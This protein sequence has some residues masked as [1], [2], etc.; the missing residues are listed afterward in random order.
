M[1]FPQLPV[2]QRFTYQGETLVK[3][4][5]LTA[6]NERGGNT[7]LMSRS[8]VVV[9]ATGPAVPAAPPSVLD[10][11]QVQAALEVFAGRWRAALADPATGLDGPSRERL[12][13]AL[14]DG[15]AELGK[16]LGLPG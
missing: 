15:L 2:G 3:V 6:C 14:A 1:K 13:Q 10:G 5:P 9:P 4:G 8:A 7:R 11:T 16:A 12:E